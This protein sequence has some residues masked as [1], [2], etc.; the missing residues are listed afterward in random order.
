MWGFT[1]RGAVA[2]ALDNIVR[3][4][5]LRKRWPCP[6]CDCPYSVSWWIDVDHAS[7]IECL[8]CGACYRLD[9]YA[10]DECPF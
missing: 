9:D 8:R 10:G 4:G 3:D 2:A 5:T 6:V 7:A 1:V